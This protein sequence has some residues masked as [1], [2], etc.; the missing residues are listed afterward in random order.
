MID[1]NSYENWTS[2]VINQGL[3]NAVTLSFI[4]YLRKF[5]IDNFSFR[6]KSYVHKESSQELWDGHL[7]HGSPSS[8]IDLPMT[9]PPDP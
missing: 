3:I 6:R 9:L 8:Y 5:G 4:L 7:E 1:H 2:L